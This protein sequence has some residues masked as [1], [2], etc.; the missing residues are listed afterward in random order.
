MKKLII[1]Q[2]VAPDYR[3]RFFEH[4]HKKLGK[5]F[6][7][8]TGDVDFQKSI[9][10]DSKIDKTKIKNIFFFKRSL[11]FQFGKHWRDLFKN[12]V[13]V[14]GLNPRIISSWVFLILRK[15]LGL[16][17]YV[18]GHAWPRKGQNSKTARIRFLMQLLATGTITYTE[19]QRD[20]ILAKH[21]KINVVSAPNA[22]YF[23]HEMQHN[24]S[25][26]NDTNNIIY[27]GRLTSAKKPF[28]LVKAFHKLLDLDMNLII[29]GDGPERKKIDEYVEVHNLDS[30]VQLMGHINDFNQLR[31]LYKQALISVSPGYVG[32][33]ITQSFAF[34]IP[35]LISR[36]ENHSP[37]IEAAKEDENAIFFETDSIENICIKL[38]KVLKN[39]HEY[40]SNRAKIANYCKRHYSIEKMSTPFI[41]LLIN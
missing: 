17:T 31:N 20:E 26:L 18:W 15:P 7:L 32:L 29:V 1:I 13:I 14:V 19:S 5:D 11:L 16:K 2:V 21:P 36:N 27:V 3:K 35:M 8:Y 30:R 22:L 33:S 41:K 25:G 9:R 34:G 10:T 28:F 40:I 24:D 6:H 23:E 37:E 39:K 38:Q 12:N 4:L